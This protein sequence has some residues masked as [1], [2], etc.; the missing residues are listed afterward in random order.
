MANQNKLQAEFIKRM[1]Q[2]STHKFIA[3]A[4][5][6]G[7]KSV[8]TIRDAIANP[9]SGTVE[10]CKEVFGADFGTI[11]QALI[12]LNVDLDREYVPEL[13]F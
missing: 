5:S 11:C 3:F 12:A 10:E 2:E 8:Y 7:S 13:L 6:S 9:A 4:F 1:K